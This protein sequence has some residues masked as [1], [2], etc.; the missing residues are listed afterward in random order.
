MSQEK[1]R[2][3]P[4]VAT[5]AI[6]VIIF[7]AV[8][9]GVMTGVIP[10]SKSSNGAL[11][12]VDGK[13]TP[14]PQTSAT[15]A[16]APRLA[17]APAQKTSAPST[18]KRSPQPKPAAQPPDYVAAN[19]APRSPGPAA[20]MP[21]A[22]PVCTECG[23]VDSINVVEKQGSGSGLG[24]V[25]GAVVGGLL[26][27]QIGSGRGNTAATVIGAAGGA[28]AGHEVEKRVKTD[29]EY[30]VTVRTD[31]GRTHSFVFDSAPV[32]AVGERVR[33]MDGRLVRG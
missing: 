8:G 16:S 19:E 18:Q 6:A 2:M 12:V 21:S 20:T 28:Y 3:N 31:D 7:S 13:M 4:L 17:T 22:P 25:G 14:A 24:A 27:H 5:A 1:S 29:K 23:V 15:P 26:G 33:V 30:H 32:Y 11:T 10:S 9:V